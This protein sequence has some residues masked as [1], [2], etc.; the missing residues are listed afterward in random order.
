MI[1]PRYKLRLRGAL[2]SSALLMLCAS[3]Q[4]DDF[5]MGANEETDQIRVSANV[6][7]SS[8][9][10]GSIP[11]VEEGPVNVKGTLLLNYRPVGTSSGIYY[12]ALADFGDAEGSDV[13]FA[14]FM[15]GDTR[16]DLKWRHIYGEGTTDQ[17]FYLSNLDTNIYTLDKS[18]ETYEVLKFDKKVNGISNNPYVAGP[19]DTRLGTN[20]L[21]FGSTT[22]KRTTGKIDFDLKHAL[23]LFKIN[24]EVYGADTD[25]YSLNLDNAEVTITNLAQTLRSF[26]RTA[27]ESFTYLSSGSTVSSTS[28]YCYYSDVK[29]MTMVDPDDQDR[30]WG[31]KKT[32]LPVD[33]FNDITKTVYSTQRFVFPP[34][35]IPPTSSYTTPL[36]TIKV[37][38]KDVTGNEKDEGFVTYSGYLPNVMF[39]ADADGNVLNSNAQT[40]S[41]KP[42]HQLNITAMINTP[43][44]ELI[45]APAKIEAWVSKDVWNLTVRQGGI[46]TPEEFDAFVA[47]YQEAARTGNNWKLERYGYEIQPGQYIFQFWDNV[48]LDIDKITNCLKQ[49]G[50]QNPPFTFLFNGYKITL[51]RNGEE[52]ET[53]QGGPGASRLYYLVTGKNTTDNYGIRNASEMKAFIN[54]V[55]NDM[56]PELTALNRYATMDGFENKCKVDITGSFEINIEDIFMKVYSELWG[57]EFDMNITEGNQ[58]TVNIGNSKLVCKSGDEVNRLL[59]LCSMQRIGLF[60]A[61]DFYFLTECYNNYYKEYP[62]ILNLFGTKSTTSETWT[63]LIKNAMIV[64]GERVFCSMKPDVANSKPN[65]SFSGSYNITYQ[66]DL[67]PCEG[68]NTTTHYYITSGKGNASSSTSMSTIVGYYNNANYNKINYFTFWSYGMF[69]NGKWIFSLQRSTQSID[70]NSLFGKM[71][72]NTEEGKYDFEFDLGTYSFSVTGMPQSAGSATTETRYFHQ[73]NSGAYNYPNSAADLKKVALGTYWQ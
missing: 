3:C 48:K 72:P 60:S 12:N 30:K 8:N 28:S 64:E 38:K 26:K 32:G 65:Y 52:V 4:D 40:I 55:D 49:N 70:Y 66:H 53:L 2:L 63:F 34:Q 37:P 62:D 58:V 16:K 41:L 22:T 67:I 50:V 31:G 68:T 24:V 42:G 11:Y 46:F 71:I 33:G 9:T 13:G 14:Y 45:F 15:S 27:P 7:A 17:K 29:N 36:L 47:D 43:G 56:F 57:Y 10:R 5:G 25:N 20:D 39:D 69:E 19:L 51:T 1:F 23:S 59:K 44:T 54:L 35:S 18:Y 73:T 6:V 61:G 21:L